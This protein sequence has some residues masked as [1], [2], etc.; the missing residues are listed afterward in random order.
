V[1]VDFVVGTS[2]GA[3]VGGLWASGLTAA[4]IEQQIAGI[5]WAE[6][7]TDKPPREMLV[8]RRRQDD[9]GLFMRPRIGL[10]HGKADGRPQ[11]RTPEPGGW[12]TT[13]TRPLICINDRATRWRRV[14]RLS[15]PVATR[16]QP[17]SRAPPLPMRRSHA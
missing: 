2:M 13:S 11:V 3:I 1:P 17:A 14:N 7:L 8:F 15:A 16:S 4:E 9:D 5:A 12:G 6:A 10:Q